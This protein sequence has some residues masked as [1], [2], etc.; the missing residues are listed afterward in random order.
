MLVFEKETSDWQIHKFVNSKL[1]HDFEFK[2]INEINF[3]IDC[4]KVSVGYVGN[5]IIELSL[6]RNKGKKFR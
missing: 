6:K 2:E 3:K 4:K 5:K 1:C